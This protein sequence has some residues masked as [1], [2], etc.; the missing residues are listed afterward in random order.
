M[1]APCAVSIALFSHKRTGAI[2]PPPI[3][4]IVVMLFSPFSVEAKDRSLHRGTAAAAAHAQHRTCFHI[5]EH[6]RI[7]PALIA[8]VSAEKGGHHCFCAARIYTN[9]GFV[10]VVMRC[11]A[12]GVPVITRN[13]YFQLAVAAYT[14][15]Q[16]GSVLCTPPPELKIAIMLYSPFPCGF[17]ETA[18]HGKSCSRGSID[19]SAIFCRKSRSAFHIFVQGIAVSV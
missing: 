11:H 13:C 4:K 19:H 2:L 8:L 5:F 12:H 18:Q 14:A 15:R 7:S 17:L 16:V 3:L 1:N 10:G 6:R 9:A